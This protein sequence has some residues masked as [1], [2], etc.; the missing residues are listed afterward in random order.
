MSDS[1]EFFEYIDMFGTRPGFYINKKAKNYTV[2]GGILT[3]IALVLCLVIFILFSIYEL[4]RMETSMTT[5]SLIPTKEFENVNIIKEKIYIPFR[6][7]D[8]GNKLINLNQLVYPLIEYIEAKKENISEYFEVKTTKINYTLC[9]ETSMVNL[10]KNHYL[11]IPLNQLYCIDVDKLDLN[12]GGYWISLFIKY[13]RIKLFL[14]ENGID[15]DEQNENCTSHVKLIEKTVSPHSLYIEFFYP[16]VQFQ[17]KNINQ[18][19]KI[20]YKQYYYSLTRHTNK[21]D[22]LILQRHILNDDLGWFSKNS[23]NSSYW[24]YSSLIGDYYLNEKDIFNTEVSTSLIYSLNIYLDSS[25]ILYTRQY[26]KIVFVF[27]ESL[28][29]MYIIF[30]VFR[31]IAKIF[32]LTN[33]TKIMFE[34]LFQNIKEK[35]NTFS[36]VLKK[37]KEKTVNKT[38]P[39]NYKGNINKNNTNLN[40]ISRVDSQEENFETKNKSNQILPAINQHMKINE[41]FEEPKDE[42]KKHCTN[43]KINQGVMFSGEEQIDKSLSV[44]KDRSGLMNSNIFKRN[45]M[46]PNIQKRYV[47]MVLFPYKNYFY[48]LF[49]RNT[50]KLKSKSYFFSK[51]F[52]DT[53]KYLAEIIDIT[54]YLRLQREFQICKSK[55]LDPQKLNMIQKEIKI[56]LG[57]RYFCRLIQNQC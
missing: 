19:V 25:V 22:R 17:P 56:N 39:V 28:P 34:I 49:I 2:L 23:K 53:Y 26:K 50:S 46:L 40:I 33:E 27:A 45:Y 30:N 13:L 24:G 37:M 38:L 15:Y 7:I 18:P 9:N 47:T 52:V 42:D 21:L 31:I 54:A 4:K 1:N 3:L 5:T 29:F 12:I 8:E 41:E 36:T 35:P 11:A 55:F 16:S 44:L 6:I 43:S 48:S 57:D 10:P 32:K 20:I 14:C 51:K